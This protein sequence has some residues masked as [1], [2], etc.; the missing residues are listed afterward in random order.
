LQFAYSIGDDF[1][2][3]VSR[4]DDGLALIIDPADLNMEEDVKHRA[5]QFAID[6][7]PQVCSRLL[8]DLANGLI[9]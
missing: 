8:R 5:L 7:F 2:F 1:K 6:H 3:Y 4:T 9:S